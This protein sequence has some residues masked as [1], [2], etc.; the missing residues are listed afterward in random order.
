MTWGTCSYMYFLDGGKDPMQ[1]DQE[2]FL[3]RHLEIVWCQ[4]SFLFVIADALENSLVNH[5]SANQSRH[6]RHGLLSSQNFSSFIAALE[7]VSNV[8]TTSAEYIVALKYL[9]YW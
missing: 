9:L 2:R 6:L 5:L 3:L 8:S 4:C 7:Y 1:N